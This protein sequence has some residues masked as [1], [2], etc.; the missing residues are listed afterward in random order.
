MSETLLGVLRVMSTH[1]PRAAALHPRGAS[2]PED[3][4]GS[5]RGCGLLEAAGR[6]LSQGSRQPGSA[7]GH[8]LVFPVAQ[9]VKNLPAVWKT[10]VQSLGWEDPLEEVMATHSSI[11]GLP[12]WLSW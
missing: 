10:G 12:L 11:L 3:S 9:L 6:G 8:R 2:E 7:G 5:Q 4:L 1:V